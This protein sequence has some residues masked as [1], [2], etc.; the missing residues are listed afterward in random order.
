MIGDRVAK[1]NDVYNA[2]KKRSEMTYQNINRREIRA[3]RKL[4][5]KQR[6]FKALKELENQLT[7]K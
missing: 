7:I 5:K 1:A 6:D 2:P 3:L 4:Y